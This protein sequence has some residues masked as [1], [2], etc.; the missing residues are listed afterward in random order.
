MR[1]RGV[2]VV[3]AV[4]AALAGG[5]AAAQERVPGLEEIVARMR[6]VNPSLQTFV[7]EQVVDLNVVGIPIRL[8]S[9]IYAARPARYKI[10]F[11]NLPGFLN[12]A[13]DAFAQAARP[14]QL[15]EDYRVVA[16]DVVVE[17]TRKM[18]HLI[19]RG[20]RP[21]VNPPSG[22]MWVDAQ[23]WVVPKMV[24]SYEWAVMTATYAF[25]D[26]QGHL[27]PDVITVAIP[28][29][30]VSARMIFHDYRFNVPLGND[31][32]VPPRQQPPDAPAVQERRP[33]GPGR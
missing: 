12:R 10:V 31:V 5:P 19:L 30:R 11:H 4:L 29:Y 33:D 27:V 28:R 14:E 2:G 13:G 16:A 23:T 32:F 18:Y 1:R 17:N 9:T 21:E 8:R 7:S 26:R 22:E 3:M 6:Q 24:L 25:A 20:R 15:I